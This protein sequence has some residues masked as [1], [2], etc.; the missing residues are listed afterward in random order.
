MWLT[1]LPATY[2]AYSTSSYL[3]IRNTVAFLAAVVV[4]VVVVALTVSALCCGFVLPFVRLHLSLSVAFTTYC[5]SFPRNFLLMS[6]DGKKI[7]KSLG[8][9]CCN[10]SRTHLSPFLFLYLVR[11]QQCNLCLCKDTHCSMYVRETHTHYVYM[12]DKGGHQP[13]SILLMCWVLW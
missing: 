8:Y 11:I 2:P 4:V 10:E 3:H 13:F 6:F 7:S 1:S 12:C 9:C 5:V